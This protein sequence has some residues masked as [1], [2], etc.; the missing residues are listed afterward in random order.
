MTHITAVDEEI[1]LRLARGRLRLD[2]KPA[3]GHQVRLGVDIH[4]VRS[5]HIP[6]RITEH[7]LDTLFLRADRQLQQN[8][9]VMHESERHFRIHQHNVIE[10]RQQVAQLR[11][12]R[13][14]ELTAHRHV[15]EQVAH[16]DI[17]PFGTRAHFLTHHIRTVNLKQRT[18]LVFR[19][20]RGHLHLCN[21]TNTRQCLSA[22]THRTQ[23]EQV[24]RLANLTRR[25]TLKR[26]PRVHLTHPDT[27]VDDL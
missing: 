1:L 7:R 11:L 14:Q 10:L 22:K 19:S 25:V 23:R 17:C 6:L 13:L 20:A 18:R 16:L 27:V 9:V 5:E 12:V 2:D 26:Q 24:L 15:E 3:D 21:R 4:E 8:L